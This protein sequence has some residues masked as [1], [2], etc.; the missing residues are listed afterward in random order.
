MKMD[1]PIAAALLLGLTTFSADAASPEVRGTWL[2]TT[3]VD[4]IRTGNN[5]ADV[6]DDLRTIGLNTV[7]VEA[8]KNGYTNYPSRVLADLTGGPDRSLFLGS[9]RDLLAQTTVAAHRNHMAHVAWFEYGFSSQFIGSGGTPSN[10]LSQYMQARGWL[11]QDVNGDY[12]NASNGFAWMNPAV[13]EV[14]QLLIDLVLEAVEHYDLDG[15]QFDDRLAWPAQFGWDPTTRSIY[16]NETGR[17]LPN[18]PNTGQLNHFND[19]RQ[20]KV[21]QFADQLTAAVR[22]ARPDL[23][24]SVSPSITPFS[25]THYNAD[26]PDWVD[27]DLFD[28]YA[29][30]AYRSSIGAFNAIVNDQV[31]PFEPGQLDRLVMGLRSN[32]SGASTPINDLLQMIDR[33]RSEGLAGHSIWYSAN[34]RDLFAAE[35][36]AYYDVAN[37]GHADHPMFGPDHRPDPIAGVAQGD[38]VFRF[39]LDTTRAYKVIARDAPTDDWSLRRAAVYPQGTAD[40]LVPG[41]FE[42]ALLVDHRPNLSAEA[43]LD[44]DGQVAINDLDTLLAQWGKA[45]RP[46]DSELGEL[47][48]DGQVDADDLAVLMGRYGQPTHSAAGVTVPEPAGLAVLVVV[49]G[50]LAPRRRR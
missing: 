25:A 32:G 9:S 38:D 33:T 7:Y 31:A 10:P 8:W 3:G 28:E 14:R 11:L 24:L 15:V 36:T 27:A 26:W 16:L 30:Q 49:G 45:Q 17:F 19:W 44:G 35:L 2:T 20:L 23:R 21:Q 22:L 40:I 48:G 43:D 5:T 42:V 12:A 50:L 29:P 4:H 34:V 13:P 6:I 37:A 47:T 18:N 46:A 41:A 39:L 1:R